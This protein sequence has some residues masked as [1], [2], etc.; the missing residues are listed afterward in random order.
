M[1]CK[2]HLE[3]LGR[4]DGPVVLAAAASWGVPHLISALV[5]EARPLVWLKLTPSDEGDPIL[6]GNKLAEAF[7]RALGSPLFGYGLPYRY[8]LNVLESHL[9]LLGPFTFAL[10][11]AQ[12]GLELARDLLALERDG[13]RVVLAFDVL[14]GAFTLPEGALL[15][16]E[17]ALR[18][19]L[20]EA[21]ELAGGRLSAEMV[22]R[23]HERTDGA[24]EPF[25]VQL[26]EMLDLPPP[27]RPTPIGP[28]PLPGH[29]TERQP[30]ELLVFLLSRERYLEALELAVRE[31][32]AEV[33]RV[34]Q[35][36]DENLWRQGV[37]REVLELLEGLPDPWRSEPGVLVARMLAA[38]LSGQEQ[39]LLPEIG[40]VLQNAELPSLRALYAE[41]LFLTGDIEECLREAER[42][43]RMK[44]S[45][46]TLYVHGSMLGL[47]DPE[48]GLGLL[49]QGLKLAEA[50]GRKL[51]TL[52]L[53]VEIAG[54][55]SALGRYR[56]AIHWAGW[57]LQHSRQEKLEQVHL[58]LSLL[59]E[60]AYSRL[61]GG[62]TAGLDEVLRREER[63]LHEVQPRLARLLKSTRADLLLGE[64]RVREALEI[65]RE[66]WRTNRQ[67]HKASA[68]ANL[69][70]RALLE[71]G[72]A[73]EALEV[74]EAA[75]ALTSDLPAFY[76]RRARLAYGMALAW[77]DPPRAIGVLEPLLSELRA[78]LLAERLAQAGLY[79]ASAYQQIGEEARA[80][81]A[82]EDVAVGVREL[83]ESG[84]R[85]LAGPLERFHGVFSL[86]EPSRA[87][88]ELQFLG[89]MTARLNGK[90][91]R[92]RTRFAE[93]L[94]VLALHPEGRT[95]EQLA[96]DLYGE[97]GDARSV[98]V[99][100]GRL[101]KQVP[102]H[103]QP[104]RLGVSVRADFLE[105]AEGLAEKRI[106]RA[107]TL[108]HGPLLPISNA[109]AV[110]E[111]RDYLDEALRQAALHAGDAET[112]W[113]LA[114][115]MQ[116]DLELWE[117][118]LAALG[119]NDPRSLLAR[120]QVRH[121]SAHYAQATP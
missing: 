97:R 31:L 56:A 73:S 3:R 104:Y 16:D 62:E 47:R 93:L 110:V 69:L 49:E 17:A 43:A 96:L 120:A 50:E 13:N 89:E 2:R 34:L 87:T 101:R 36:A 118:A 64:G 23:L 84:L 82:L 21:L 81:K 22:Q 61:L 20:P 37:Q 76:R 72:E 102:I 78:P 45:P 66:L 55:H 5:E 77:H 108:Y 115:R 91:L 103:S 88:L 79:L 68:L 4:H 41:A 42:A 8:G 44:K 10:S 54:N 35:E 112:L 85:Y 90:P 94:A 26:N 106:D 71:C 39:K 7:L 83:S 15:L 18:L 46:L 109:P 111:H 1:W 28:Q 14:P 32:P 40:R 24:Y 63:H 67:R 27:L 53:L 107:L 33:P 6:Q 52:Q 25:C 57:G 121:L 114:E 113:I 95:S 60:W 105:L 11:G 48:V 100:I 75:L 58:R 99:E 65:Y 9:E 19:T 70:V 98:K 38:I 59:N 51:L 117:A 74:A 119:K 30:T 12:H 86:F 80:A 92:L 29:A 116:D